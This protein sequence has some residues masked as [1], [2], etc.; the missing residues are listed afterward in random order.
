MKDINLH[1]NN[2]DLYRYLRN[3]ILILIKLVY[4]NVHDFKKADRLF[5][6]DGEAL[7]LL[8]KSIQGGEKRALEETEPIPLDTEPTT[9][10][11]VRK[12]M[13]RMNSQDKSRVA[14]KIMTRMNSQ[15]TPIALQPHNP[16]VINEIYLGITN[17]I[18][19]DI[20]GNIDFENTIQQ[21]YDNI[22]LPDNDSSSDIYFFFQKIKSLHKKKY[23]E[24]IKG[25]DADDMDIEGQDADHM[26]IESLDVH[27]VHYKKIFVE[28]FQDDEFIN[29]LCK[30]YYNDYSNIKQ[31]GGDDDDDVSDDV[32]LKDFE[33]GDVF[34]QKINS[35]YEKLISF[36]SNI[37]KEF[38][39]FL[40]DSLFI[41]DVGEFT[42]SIRK[43]INNIYEIYKQSDISLILSVTEDVSFKKE[44]NIIKKELK[45]ININ[46]TNHFNLDKNT[47]KF[48]EFANMVT[49]KPSEKAKTNAMQNYKDFDILL[50]NSITNIINLLVEKPSKKKG[51]K[52]DIND[53]KKINN[54]QILMMKEGMQWFKNDNILETLPEPNTD[55]IELNAI[56][57]I[58]NLINDE[59]E[60]LSLLFNIKGLGINDKKLFDRFLDILENPKYKTILTNKNIKLS[61]EDKKLYIDDSDKYIKAENDLEKLKLYIETLNDETSNKKYIINNAGNLNELSVSLFGKDDKALLPNKKYC[62]ISSII[63]SASIQHQGCDNNNE[64]IIEYGNINLRFNYGYDNY[65]NIIMTPNKENKTAT[66]TL[67]S[68]LPTHTKINESFVM[69]LNDPKSSVK[70]V[71]LDMIKELV[72]SITS[73]MNENP[74]EHNIWSYISNKKRDKVVKILA[75]SYKKTAGDWLQEINGSL[76]DFGYEN[77]ITDDNKDIFYKTGEDRKNSERLFFATDQPS[78]MHWMFMRIFLPD[79]Y[80]NKSAYG[81]YIYANHGKK[82]DN[83]KYI[84]YKLLLPYEETDGTSYAKK[85]KIGGKKTRHKKRPN[86]KTH[87]NR[88]NKITNKNKKIKKTIKHKK[89]PKFTRKKQKKL[90]RVKYS[91]KNKSKKNINIS[92]KKLKI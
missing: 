74:T 89:N 48:K 33:L 86:H 28:I 34:Q 59:L 47:G 39:T 91:V 2:I 73:S 83:K 12:I 85:Q 3:R 22:F 46:L 61:K 66:L 88:K 62:P 27:D 54:V 38:T 75:L 49:R 23:E 50:W 10:R 25:Q 1:N 30:I 13:P 18:L 56:I 72:S 36:R 19:N 69:D 68:N 9:P 35:F 40:N 15:D 76:S 5:T 81:G 87:I 90:K 29:E 65:F 71:Y 58:Y 6:K 21:L 7:N 77:F 41:N 64:T 55:N 14:R 78:I 17:L 63:D 60:K 52:I 92:L 80:I 67:M 70:S 79:E 53:T 11:V 43:S 31:F 82:N 26:D 51:L 84:T 57:E 37:D 24:K 8:K 42:E 4:D 16:Y 45:F 44:F 32:K 20:I